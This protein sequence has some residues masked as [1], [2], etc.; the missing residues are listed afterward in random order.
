MAVIL[1][2]IDRFKLIND[3][4]GHTA[5]DDHGGGRDATR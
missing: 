1:V 4:L 5:G 2:G 3:T